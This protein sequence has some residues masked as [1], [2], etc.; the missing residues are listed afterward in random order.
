MNKPS[1]PQTF[2]KKFSQVHL[3]TI[4][5][6]NDLNDGMTV[7]LNLIKTEICIQ[8]SK[9]LLIFSDE[10]LLVWLNTKYII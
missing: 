1:E 3:L 9:Y 2:R 6:F 8:Y 7:G 10:K 5:Q 4:H